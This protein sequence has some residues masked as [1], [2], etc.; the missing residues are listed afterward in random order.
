MRMLLLQQQCLERPA[1]ALLLQLLHC[2]PWPLLLM[3]K[4]WFNS[5]VMLLVLQ[6]AVYSAA[7]LPLL[8]F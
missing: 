5:T 2:A 7:W 8:L 3:V 4:Q 1:V 6:Q